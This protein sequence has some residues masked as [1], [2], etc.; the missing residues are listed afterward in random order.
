MLAR[1]K[2]SLDSDDEEVI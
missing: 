2:K 1:Q